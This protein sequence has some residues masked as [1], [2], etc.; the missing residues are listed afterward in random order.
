MNENK[1]LPDNAVVRI[2]SVL[3]NNIPFYKRLQPIDSAAY[4]A[5]PLVTGYI[6]SKLVGREIAKYNRRVPSDEGLLTHNNDK[7]FHQ[8][9]MYQAARPG[10]W[11]ALGAALAGELKEYLDVADRRKEGKSEEDIQ[12]ER[13]KDLKNNY[14]A[15]RMALEDGRPVDQVILP[16]PTIVSYRE[17]KKNGEI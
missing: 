10:I 15:I 13:K 2:F 1:E 4:S 7:Y 11:S 14:E 3:D 9:S 16:N 5:I 6:N 17:K 8:H 12:K